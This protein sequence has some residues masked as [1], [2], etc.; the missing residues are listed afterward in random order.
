[1]SRGNE[2][3][4]GTGTRVRRGLTVLLLTCAAAIV[5]V[6]I[7]RSAP[8]RYTMAG[9]A[10]AGQ[11]EVSAERGRYLIRVGG[12]NDCHTPGFMQHG[13]QVPERDWLT[14]IPVGWKGPWGTTYASNLRLF[15]KDF[16]EATW[17]QVLRARN[18]RPPMPWANLHAMTDADLR[19]V[20]RYIRSLPL[21]GEKMPEYVPPG[22]EPSTAYFDFT[23]QMPPAQAGAR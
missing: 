20:H 13:E 19:S 21:I 9:A 17:V 23:P 6:G 4:A 5:A 3:V 10:P 15:A 12:C 16:D 7:S 11:T 1:M 18:T 2:M 14:G 22:R 8:Q